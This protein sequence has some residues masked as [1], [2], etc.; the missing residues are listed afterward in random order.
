MNNMKYITIALLLIANLLFAQDTKILYTVSMPKPSNHLFEIELSVQNIQSSGGTMDFILPSWRSGRYVIFNFSSG[1]QEFS[2]EGTGG[3]KLKWHK[4]NK[5]TWQVETAGENNIVIKYKVYAN[6]FSNRTCGLDDEHAFIDA[7]AVLMY[8]EKLRHNPL[9]LK[10]IPYR[11]W[12]VATGMDRMPGDDYTLISPGYDY[13]A[14]CPIEMGNLKCFEFNSEEKKH[15]ICFSGD[16][17]FNAD[18]L[19]KDLSRIVEINYTFWGKLPYEHFDFIFQLTT[20]DYGGTEHL[21]SFVID[22]PPLFFSDKESYLGFLSTCSHEFFHTWNVKQL[23]PKGIDPYDFTKEN[24]TEELWIAEGTTTY[25]QNIMLLKAGYSSDKRY[26][27]N[28]ENSIQNDIE[29][30]GNKIQTLAESSFD[31]WVKYWANTPNKWIAESDYYSKGANVSLLLDLEIRNN[32]SNK[33][34]LDNVMRAMFERFPLNK[35]GYTNSDFIKVCEEFAGENL[36]EF[37][38]SYLYGLTELNWD[39]NL[40]YA[41][42]KL[43]RITSDPKP[44]VGI[45]THDADD[46][47]MIS[48]VVQGS[49]AADAGLDAGDEIVALNGMKITSSK[50]SSR[51]G[52]MKEGDIAKF[53]IIR[54]D[55]T[56]DIDVTIKNTQ[57]TSYKIEKVESPSELQKTIYE[58]WL[59]SKW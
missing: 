57:S 19:I 8:N 15:T 45:S 29:R 47:L 31:A 58:S 40:S 9:E 27:D 55:K 44:Y 54:H 35:G 11:D 4:T 43:K 2:A 48:S 6:E 17:N 22:A 37:F 36:Q 23:R 5:D 51:I 42:L 34:S 41:G 50:L 1:I 38:D 49:P 21:N 53:T 32:S 24:Y 33:Y 16:G 59:S 39:K 12:T 30:P 3:T 20:Q 18:T 28:L 13:L 10:I 7:S 46:M 26:L 14:D 56:R 25:Y 52:D